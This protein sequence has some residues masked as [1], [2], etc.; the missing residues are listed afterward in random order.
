M[1]WNFETPKD[2][3]NVHFD[4]GDI[5]ASNTFNDG[6]AGGYFQVGDVNNKR[7]VISDFA[8]FDNTN[9]GNSLGEWLI[10]ARASGD[11]V[12]LTGPTRDGARFEARYSDEIEI[13]GISD[14]FTFP[15][16]LGHQIQILTGPNAGTYTI[17]AV[18][19]PVDRTDILSK[20]AN[21]ITF[22]TASV[23]AAG[24]LPIKEYSARVKVSN[25]PAAGFSTTS[26]DATW[27]IVP[28]FVTDAGPVT[29]ELADAGSSAAAV[30]TFRQDLS[31]FGLAIGDVLNVHRSTVLSAQAL[32]ELDSVD[33][34][35]AGTPP[36]YSRYAFWLY[37]PFGWL[38][39]LIDSLTAAGYIP[40]FDRLYADAAGNHILED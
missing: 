3:W 18:L 8:A 1:D 23:S 34:V 7:L 33:F 19:D 5:A 35:A 37:D 24:D 32:D 28:Q 21:L 6:A 4:T 9:G 11:Q 25:P 14:A 2:L 26:T 15:D 17:S 31:A 16:S 22:M 38:R 20:Y 39:T 12:T 27:R 13:R 10:S 30:L 40:D 29:A 36:T